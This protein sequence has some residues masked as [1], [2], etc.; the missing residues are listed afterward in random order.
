MARTGVRVP[1][2]PG[3]IGGGAG[4]VFGAGG[5]AGG[6][7]IPEV[8]ILGATLVALFAADDTA[9]QF[10]NSDMS[11]PVAEGGN[12]VK[13]RAK[14]D[15]TLV[16]SAINGGPVYSAT[17]Y[18]GAVP[19]LDYGPG[20]MVSPTFLP[21]DGAHTLPSFAIAF[22]TK[23]GLA[24]G[25]LFQAFRDDGGTDFAFGLFDSG[26]GTFG[27]DV[28]IE[29]TSLGSDYS[30]T[31]PTG[32]PVRFYFEP[33]GTAV[34]IRRAIGTGTPAVVATGTV[35]TLS[36]PYGSAAG[37]YPGLGYFGRSIGGSALDAIKAKFA[38]IAPG[39]M[40]DQRRNDLDALWRSQQ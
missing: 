21:I 18:N 22:Q 23:P 32:A 19:G 33:V 7:S 11:A 9:N 15:Q 6:A 17:S 31:T 25:K 28:G 39:G 4:V 29:G 3:F 37:D 1:G 34:T 14:N 35:P 16:C 5:A 27:F 2:A 24:D 30:S 8:S 20:N 12:V 26:S 13:H 36:L 38:W 10:S 40:T